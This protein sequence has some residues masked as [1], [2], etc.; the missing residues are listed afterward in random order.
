MGIGAIS[1][2]RLEISE[3]DGPA[4]PVKLNMVAMMLYGMNEGDGDIVGDKVS[5]T[6]TCYKVGRETGS[7][8]VL[9][10]LISLLFRL[11]SFDN[12]STP[13]T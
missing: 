1:D 7:E 5:G 9:F 4:L 11:V 13:D 10:L 12:T 8:K 2:W 6:G 3:D